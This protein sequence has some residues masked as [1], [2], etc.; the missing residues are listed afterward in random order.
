MAIDIRSCLE[1]TP[2]VHLCITEISIIFL[3]R[4]VNSV[5]ENIKYFIITKPTYDKK[6]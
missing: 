1:T 3:Y 2:Q 5:H 6:T 4:K